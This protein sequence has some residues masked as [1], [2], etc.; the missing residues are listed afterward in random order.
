MPYG[1][2]L[3]DSSDSGSYCDNNDRLNSAELDETEQLLPVTM[4]ELCDIDPR[5]KMSRKKKLE[6]R[7]LLLDGGDG[8]LGC[9]GCME[10]EVY[11]GVSDLLKMSKKHSIGMF[12]FNSRNLDY[13]WLHD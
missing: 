13:L 6:K 1:H 9:C 11:I 12:R 5:K 8:E 7:P 3:N 4:E 2:G 10:G